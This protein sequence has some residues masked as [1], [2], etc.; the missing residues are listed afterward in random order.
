M[1]YN[2]LIVNSAFSVLSTHYVRCNFSAR[3]MTQRSNYLNLFI[4]DTV[5]AEVSWRFHRHKA[6]ELDQVI[7]H[8]V[9]QSPRRFVI[10]G[11]ILY[12]E[13]FSGRNLDVVDVMRV[14]KRG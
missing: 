5:C 4:A 2:R 13:C 12:S 3:P 10:S 11:A 8:H 1:T 9:P 14:P 6:E 7:L